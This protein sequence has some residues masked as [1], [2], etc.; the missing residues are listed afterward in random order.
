MSKYLPSK[1]YMLGMLS[2]VIIMI[3]FWFF[4]GSSVFEYF[5]FRN[6]PEISA[7]RKEQALADIRFY[8]PLK[9]YSLLAAVSIT[10]TSGLLFVVGLVV[11]K[12]RKSSVFMAK[13]GT[14]EIP[15]S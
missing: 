15:I 12:V 2:L 7:E 14:S 3:S 8:K 5:W 11:A 9:R 6:D 10:L 1:Q 4:I 13:T